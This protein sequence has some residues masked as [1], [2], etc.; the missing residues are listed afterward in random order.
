MIVKHIGEPQNVDAFVYSKYANC[1]LNEIGK[2]AAKLADFSDSIC[3]FRICEIRRISVFP[4]AFGLVRL[5][6]EI[7]KLIYAAGD[8]ICKGNS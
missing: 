1:S 3:G 6:L 5:G 7:R 8:P 4:I 2:T